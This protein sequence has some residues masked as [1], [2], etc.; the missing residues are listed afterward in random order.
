MLIATLNPG[1]TVPESTY[2]NNVK[3]L[4]VTVN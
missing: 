2:D 1:H 3:Q 4:N